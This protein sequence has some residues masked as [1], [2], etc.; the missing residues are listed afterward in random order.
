MSDSFSRYPKQY[1]PNNRDVL[2]IAATLLG[3]LRHVFSK[4]S[5]LP[6]DNKHSS[7]YL[8]PHVNARKLQGDSL[9]L[10]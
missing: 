10:C 4:P 1:D 2:Q 5:Y 9:A 7:Y 3:S 6:Q 8:T